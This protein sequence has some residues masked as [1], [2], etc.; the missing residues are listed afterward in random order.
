MV[1]PAAVNTGVDTVKSNNRTRGKEAVEEKTDDTTNC[2]FSEQIQGIIDL[3]KELGY[4]NDE[5]P[6]L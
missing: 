2:V 5:E 6:S 1:D 3:E 4:N